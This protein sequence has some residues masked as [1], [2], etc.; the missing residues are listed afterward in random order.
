MRL[1]DIRDGIKQLVRLP[2]RTH[3]Q[4][5]A[6]ADAEL[7]SLLAER[8]DYLVARGWAPSDARTEALKRLGPP[9]NEAA[10]LLHQSARAR[11]RR[12]GVSE[13]LEELLLDARQALRAL[14]RDARFATVAMLV[15]GLGIG[16]SVTVFSVANALLLRPL[17]FLNAG[18]LV[19]I[20]NNSEEGLSGRTVQAYTL[21][22][23]RSGNRSFTD[24]AG[25]HAFYSQNNSRVVHNGETIRL[26]RVPVTENFF[27]LLGVTPLL[28]RSFSAD[29]STGLGPQAVMLSYELWKNR[30]NSDRS[31]V[32]QSIVMNDAPATVVGVLPA[33]FDFV[34]VFAPGTRADL[35]G[36][37]PLSESTN[38]Q[39]N[40]L[41]MVG[42]LRPGS[43]VTS[44]QADVKV[45]AERIKQATPKRNDLALV[46]MSL[47]LHV[48]GSVQ[49]SLLV[50]ALSVGVVMLIVCA[51]LSNLLLARATTRQREMAVRVALGAG[52]R[53][54]IRQA[55]TESVVL[56]ICGA[57]LG[58]LLALVGTRIITG[59]PVDL[60]LLA[61]VRIDGHALM[62]TVLLALGSGVVFGLAPAFQVPMN[63][64]TSALKE[65]GRNATGGTGGRLLR[66]G[67]V[68]AE[69]AMACLLLVGAGLLTRSFVNVLKVDLGF[70]PARV[71]AM[72]ADPDRSMLASEEKFIGYVDAVLLA[73]RAVPGVS[74][75]ALSDGLPLSGN[76]TWNVSAR[77]V[78]RPSGGWPPAFIHVVSDGFM[79]TMGVRLIAGRDF[80]LRDGA[81]SDSVIIVNEKLAKSLWPGQDAIGKFMNADKE[82]RVVG[83]VAD[84]RILA[85]EKSAGAELYLPIRQCYDFSSIHLVVRSTIP[86]ASIARVLRTAMGDV[87]PG[88]AVNQLD[89][90]EQIVESAVSPRRFLTLLLGGFALFALLL[91]LIGIYGVISY[92][93]THRTQE[94][95]VRMALGA[96]AGQVQQRIFRETMTLT[97]AG[98]LIGTV[99]SWALART[100]GSL[101]FGV[102]ATDPVTF[103]GML[104]T[105]TIVA[106]FSGYLPARRASRIDPMMAL[107]GS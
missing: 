29:E 57:I 58:L 41:F 7:E 78:S 90:M 96:S 13:M 68:V 15:V 19:W 35:F 24:V 81:N 55:L 73:A 76:R 1:H 87:A 8:T 6:D 77:D 92:T 25:Y 94:I 103:A 51:N 72:R 91:A 2:L 27:P 3:E 44:S 70:Q 12:K 4:M 40:L 80:D 66:Q 39:G 71:S 107:R 84:V 17:P 14:K 36:P 5:D 65:G 42:R 60:P 48:S 20:E 18:E 46:A 34:S 10:H 85:P 30:Y 47:R 106:A 97:G 33:S 82:R 26:T 52:R 21:L 54:L 98:M 95:G 63:S 79:E 43:S 99:A 61:S 11:E 59:L 69:I 67:F 105:L 89:N 22:D 53:R 56:S 88:L 45:V 16:A 75:A 37:V 31:I 101:L 50:L 83:V 9:L 64:L 74:S 102:S 28:G 23:L 49:S 86:A 32:G 100:L 62:F 38:R 93:V 104:V